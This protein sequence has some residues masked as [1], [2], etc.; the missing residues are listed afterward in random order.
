[1]IWLWVED[2]DITSIEGDLPISASA[3]VDMN[4]ISDSPIVAKL[5]ELQ[6]K[7]KL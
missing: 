3:L 5:Q 1:M 7:S 2:M 4:G 6:S